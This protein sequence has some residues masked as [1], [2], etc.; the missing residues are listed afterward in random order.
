MMN[1]ATNPMANS[2]GVVNLMEPPH[3]VPTQLKILI[4]VGMA[5][6]IVDNANAEFATGPRPAA[7]MWCAHTPQPMNP[8]A[9]PENTTTGYPNSGLRENT[10]RTSDTMPM[11]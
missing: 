4:P 11:A 2:I 8:I 9:M 6:N 10:G 5:M 7:N 3:I 1:S